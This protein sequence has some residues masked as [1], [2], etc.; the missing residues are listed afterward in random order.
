MLSYRCP[1]QPGY[2]QGAT[3]FHCLN[4]ITRLVWHGAF[5]HLMNLVAVVG[6]KAFAANVFNTNVWGENPM[7]NAIEL[8]KMK[9][10]EYILS[11][12]EI[13]AKYM[14]DVPE[15]HKLC[16]ALN[17]FIA[18]QQ[19]VNYVVETLGLT[20]AKLQEVQNWQYFDISRLL[21]LTV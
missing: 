11:I 13:K 3:R 9:M 5:D 18:N 1:Q 12:D 8:K 2:K 21:P 4:L 19:A 16:V 6:E 15:L 17:Q 20:E 14:S 7:M 10:I